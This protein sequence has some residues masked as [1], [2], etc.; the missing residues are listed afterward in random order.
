MI[1][2]ADNLYNIKLEFLKFSFRI[3]IRLLSCFLVVA[4]EDLYVDIET[5]EEGSTHTPSLFLGRLY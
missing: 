5:V 2:N 1:V 4:G 3:N